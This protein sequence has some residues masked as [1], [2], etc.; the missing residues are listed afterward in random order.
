MEDVFL[1]NISSGYR[2]HV[3]S[4]GRNMSIGVGDM[5]LGAGQQVK[6][7]PGRASGRGVCLSFRGPP[8]PGGSRDGA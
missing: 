2:K 5:S 3:L 7:G 1:K 6:R 8:G 4:M